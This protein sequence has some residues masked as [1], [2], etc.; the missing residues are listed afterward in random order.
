MSNH[1]HLLASSKQEHVLPD[2]IRDFKKYTS[3][4]VLQAIQENEQESRR[5]WMLSIFKKAGEYNSNNVDF[6]FWRQDNK[7]I[8]LTDNEQI[9]KALD[10]VHYNPVEAGIVDEP[11]HYVYSSARNYSGSKGLISVDL[12]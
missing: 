4:Q 9:E 10:Y 2:I 3:K 6:Q 5:E 7:P 12:I 11:H 1:V 8:E